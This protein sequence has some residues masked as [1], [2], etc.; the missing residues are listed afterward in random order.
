[1]R[2]ETAR[3][4]GAPGSGA[5]ET[6]GS[7]GA[8]AH[9]SRRPAPRSRSVALDEALARVSIPEVHLPRP[10]RFATPIVLAALAV[11]A[12]SLIA[13]LGDYQP[14]TG[15]GGHGGGG[16]SGGAAASS[17]SSST[18]SAS[19]TSSSG[20]AG[21]G[22]TGGTG[23]LQVTLAL[24]AG[25]AHDCAIRADHGLRCW[26]SNLT[27]QL[28]MPVQTT[29]FW[30]SPV[31]VSL[32]PDAL[33]VATGDR[34]TCAILPTGEVS[35]WGDNGHF[36]CG[37]SAPQTITTP[38][39]IGLHAEE[40][41]AGDDFTCALL[42][43][44][45]NHAV[46]C[47]GN[48][49]GGSLGT[50]AASTST[51][52]DTGLSGVSAIATCSTCAQAC[53]RIGGTVEC[54]G[55]GPQYAAHV[56][57]G[58]IADAQAIALGNGQNSGSLAGEMLFVLRS[59]GEVVFTQRKSDGTFAVPLHYASGIAQIS[60]GDHLAVLTTAGEYQFTYAF[61]PGQ[62]P[63]PLTTLSPGSLPASES[64]EVVAGRGQDCMRGQTSVHCVGVDDLGQV[65]N[66][67]AEKVVKAT[68]VVSG[69]GAVFAGPDCTTVK[70]TDGSFA[71]FGACGVYDGTNGWRLVPTPLPAFNPTLT[72]LATG[73]AAT[74]GSAPYGDSRGYFEDTNAAF[75]FFELAD[76]VKA[77]T[78]D[79]TPM[80]STADYTDLVISK[81]WTLVRHA[82]GVAELTAVVSI[83]ATHGLFLSASVA[84]GAVR[85]LSGTTGVAGAA[86]A[87]HMCTWDATGVSCFGRNQTHQSAPLAG[88]GDVTNP[89]A[90]TM[91]G[92]TQVALGGLHTC[93][94]DG[95]GQVSCWGTNVDGQLGSPGPLAAANG[96]VPIKLGGAN[97]PA[98]LLAGGDDYACAY[99]PV[100]HQVYCWGNNEFG[101]CGDGTLNSPAT[102]KPVLGL[103]P[104]VDVVQLTSGRHHVCAR[105][106]TGEVDC[107]GYSTDGQVGDGSAYNYYAWQTLTGF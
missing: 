56:P 11:P 2:A 53:A 103:T 72:L 35:C 21:G 95:N 19:S 48:N 20:A 89:T 67:K 49:A 63:P 104:T 13:G 41:V 6:A 81:N 55:G 42:P 33:G 66:G 70:H 107:W 82:T 52:Q 25:S 59:G 45:Q 94:L 50:T 98:T 78:V 12:C 32:V 14:A 76:G 91:P 27:G 99:V 62:A 83:A 96:T 31:S 86:W 5:G 54:W 36:A 85:T 90:I 69:V 17:T 15:S 58:G 87:S 47:W 77:A 37:V 65:G 64:L 7:P 43:A 34:H 79:F 26:G 10:L 73:P 46:K 3:V 97:H 61:T 105:L 18:S 30:S 40:I 71:A 1:M 88:T 22:G 93:A 28:G 24:R 38:K 106:A 23:P 74:A 102:P 92:V 9:G 80:G 100:D 57:V 39:G 44:A 51:P 8:L 29:S 84:P 4:K 16:G 68:P 101:T 75:G 60:A